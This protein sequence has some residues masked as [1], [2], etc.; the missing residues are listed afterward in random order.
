MY[1]F[2]ALAY[3]FFDG[4]LQ[5]FRTLEGALMWLAPKPD[6]SRTLTRQ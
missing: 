3:K 5:V 2:E 1:E 4:G 6:S